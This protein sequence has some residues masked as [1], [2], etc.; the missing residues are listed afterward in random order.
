MDNFINGYLGLQNLNE[1]NV[2]SIVAPD[3]TCSNIIASNG[4]ISTLNSTT[5]NTSNLSFQSATGT[6]ISY[7]S[8]TGNS[9][10]V[11]SLTYGTSTGNTGFVNAFTYATSTGNTGYVNALTYATSTGNTEYVNALTYATSTGNTGYVNALTYATSTGNTGFVNTLLFRT[12]TG[13]QGTISILNSTSIRVNSSMQNFT[14]TQGFY[15]TAIISDSRV[16][17][18]F[19]LCRNI[20][21]FHTPVYQTPNDGISNPQTLINANINGLRDS[22]ANWQLT[23]YTPD[24]NGVIPHGQPF[25]IKKQSGFGSVLD[26]ARTNLNNPLTL[27]GG[28]SNMLYVFIYNSITQLYEYQGYV[29]V[30]TPDVLPT[31]NQFNSRGN[32]FTLPSTRGSNNNILTSNGVGSSSWNS[33]VNVSS[34]TVLQGTVAL[35]S[36]TFSGDLNTGIYQSA[37]DNLDIATN[38]VSRVNISNSGIFTQDIRVNSGIG[39]QLCYFQPTSKYLSSYNQLDLPVSTAT[40]NA[41]NLKANI[42]NP[43]F[44]GVMTYQMSTGN[45]GFVNALTYTTSTG[46]SAFVNALTYATSTGN[47]G[48]VNALTYATSTGNTGF[49]NAL[50]Y[51]TST[52]NTGFVNAL[53][54][55]T[56]TGNSSFVNALNFTNATGLNLSINDIQYRKSQLQLGLNASCSGSNSIAIGSSPTIPLNA[57]NNI[58][59]GYLPSITTATSNENIVMGTEAICYNN[60]N[61]VMGRRAHTNGQSQ[62]I[63][64][65]TRNEYMY[66]GANQSF[67]VSHI[68]N[69]SNNNILQYNP[70]TYEITHSNTIS[71]QNATITN[72]NFTTST[73]VNSFISGTLRAN[74]LFVD[75][76]SVHIGLNAGASSQGTFGIAIGRDSCR[77]NQGYGSIGIGYNAQSTGSLNGCIAIGFEAG[78]SNQLSDSIAVGSQAGYSIQGTNGIAIGRLAGRNSQGNNAIAVGASAGESNQNLDS[79]A[80]GNLA[81]RSNQRHY[82]VSIGSI[83]GN[84]S[85][86]TGAVAIGWE[87][88]EFS[89]GSGSIA[90][91][92]NAGNNSQRNEAV[93]IGFNSGVTAQKLGAIAIGRGSGNCNQDEYSIA[94]G[95]LSALENQS[96]RCIAIGFNAGFSSQ[97]S[98]ALAIGDRAGSIDQKAL[99]V[100]IGAEAGYCNQST[101][102]VAIG[103]KAGIVGQHENTIIINAS[104]TTSLNSDGSNR[105]F[106]KPI[107][108]PTTVP[109]SFYQMYYNPTTGEVIYDAP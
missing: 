81:G 5:I 6:S 88:G 66:A 95:Y 94:I 58:V 97:R 11:N 12:C 104:S 8:S 4:Q 79:I 2:D 46:N 67:Y 56:S 77:Y 107:R 17:N 16:V 45:T 49:V 68:R 10:F 83:A 73:G 22:D 20:L 1:I 21:R 101:G 82:S 75:N 36:L 100:A 40:Q 30:S 25:Y 57:N 28:Y 13:A 90:I 24:N 96:N 18:N 38:G 19:D 23:Y 15:N 92:N 72:L 99:T 102:S 71:A 27:L 35:P 89:Q 78:Y 39:G 98:T 54:Y 34:I 3:I 74:D 41:L 69:L 7:V 93:A 31:A 37:S 14:G 55:T 80:I 33:T 60:N 70:V 52:G 105:F 53:T 59:I 48:F 87:S 86:G 50:T 63:I 108:G 106:I 62:T 84:S 29:N 109:S 91:G 32:S 76:S 103:Y 26:T 9:A 47:T 64:L 65:N 42:S 61:I 43:T 51:A 85:Q 44:T